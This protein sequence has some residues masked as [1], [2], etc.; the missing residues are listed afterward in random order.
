MTSCFVEDRVGQGYQNC[1]GDFQGTCKQVVFVL[2]L[3][4][5]T[6]DHFN[7]TFSLSFPSLFLRILGLSSV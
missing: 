1:T 6:F 2:K 3:I 4:T 5:E 7:G